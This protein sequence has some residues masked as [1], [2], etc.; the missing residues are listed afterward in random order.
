MQI[1]FPN[2]NQ[3]F[4]ASGSC[5]PVNQPFN[6]SGFGSINLNAPHGYPVNHPFNS[7]GG[8]PPHTVFAPPMPPPGAYGGY[9]PHYPI[10]I[11]P[12]SC[13]HCGTKN[14]CCLLN[15]QFQ[16]QCGHP[17]TPCR[18]APVKIEVEEPTD[19]ICHI[20]IL[21]SKGCPSTRGLPC[22][23]RKK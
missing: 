18:N 1:P 7:S 5:T 22:P 23:S 15:G 20:T 14:S 12:P 10:H 17:I 6:A 4:N 13:P 11:S 9:M 19:C 2:N 3:P 8:P 21:V 16:F